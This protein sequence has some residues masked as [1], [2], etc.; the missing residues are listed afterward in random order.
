MQASVQM[1]RQL[2]VGRAG[3][4]VYRREAVEAAQLAGC[5][6]DWRRGKTALPP[7][8]FELALDEGWVL[9]CSLRQAWREGLLHWTP[10]ALRGPHWLRPW[11]EYL[12]LAAFEQREAVGFAAVPACTQ[13]AR[14][15]QGPVLAELRGLDATAARAQLLRLLRGYAE[16]QRAP[17]AFFPK[18]AWAYV[19]TLAGAHGNDSSEER[20]LHHARAEYDHD[21]GYAEN[22]DAWIRPR[23]PRSRSVRRGAPVRRVR[24]PRAGC[25]RRAGRYLAGSAAMNATLDSAE[26]DRVTPD[27]GSGDLAQDLPLAGTQLIEAS[28][29]TGK[30]WTIAGLYLRCIVERRLSVRDVLVVTFTRAATEELKDRLRARLLLCADAAEARLRGADAPV[31]ADAETA[32]ARTLIERALEHG[33]PPEALARRLRLAAVSMDEAAI[34]TIHAFCQ[35]VL[36]EQAFAS[37]EALDAGEL[38]G[39]DSDLIEQIAA[40]FW[41][42]TPATPPAPPISTCC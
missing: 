20:A 1:R 12:A 14:G 3:A 25:L 13:I 7:A 36:R 11:I 39:S 22:S 17:L 33:E 24:A 28:A 16:G 4:E 8:L 34:H 27:A 32:F 9:D 37:G 26:L 40:D 15:E 41:R 10:G 6:D 21:R 18:A 42:C 29:G 31:E 19:Q 38:V 5:V 23:L 2:P 35:R 30:T